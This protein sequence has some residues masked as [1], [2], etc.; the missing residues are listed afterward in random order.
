[1]VLRGIMSQG[2][3][4]N[5]AA[6]SNLNEQRFASMVLATGEPPGLQ[7]MVSLWLRGALD[8]ATLDTMIAYSRVRTEW[9]AQVKASGQSTMGGADAIEAA[10][11]G[12]ITQAQAQTLF[13]QAGGIPDQYATIM[14][15]AGDAIGIEQAGNLF[16]H[17][18][19]SQS[20]FSAV[21]KYSRVNPTFEPMS[22][23]LRFKWLSAYQIG[24][25]LKAGACT[26]AQATLWMTQD[27]YPA[28]QIA[29]F[30]GSNGT[31]TTVTAK[32]ETESLV[33]E[34]YTLGVASRAETLVTLQ[35]LGYTVAD[36]EFILTVTDAKTAAAATKSAVTRVQSLFLG[37]HITAAVAGTDLDALGVPAAQRDTLLT[38]WGNELGSVVKSLTEAQWAAAF[39]DG[40]IDQPQFLAELVA[41]GY[42]QALASILVQIN[43]GTA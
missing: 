23:L 24:E 22:E 15:A 25:A 26:K 11:K 7:E 10:I 13:A 16:M 33:V 37:H 40:I 34:G 3:G 28:D 32:A 8:E 18:L 9:S 5:E 35:H 39:K 27:G 41:M 38:Q 1:M 19:I 12:V 4:S 17:N 2:D 21:V 42:P 6:K 14:G 20:D 29:A 43:G 31:A 30:V 36:S